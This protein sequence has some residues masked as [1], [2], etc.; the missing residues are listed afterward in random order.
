MVLH[1]PVEPAGVFG[2]FELHDWSCTQSYG[3][4]CRIQVLKLL[5][6]AHYFSFFVILGLL[7]SANAGSWVQ[8]CFGGDALSSISVVQIVLSSSSR[9]LADCRSI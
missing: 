5:P 3:K 4:V 2:N 8:D 6:K 9:F 1:R 7:V